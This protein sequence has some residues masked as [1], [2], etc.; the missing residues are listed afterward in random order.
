MRG[1]EPVIA[2]VFVE[3]PPE[4]VYEYFTRPEAIVR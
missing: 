3:A 4:R 1:A 2:S